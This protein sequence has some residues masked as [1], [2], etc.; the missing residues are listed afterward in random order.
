MHPSFYFQHSDIYFVIKRQQGYGKS[1]DRDETACVCV[2]KHACKRGGGG[3][4]GIVEVQE[5]MEFISF[6]I[7]AFSIRHVYRYDRCSELSNKL[8]LGWC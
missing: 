8:G 2:C 4:M 7:N 3:C 1:I 5:R 6:Y